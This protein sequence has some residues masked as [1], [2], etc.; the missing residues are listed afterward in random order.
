[1]TAEDQKPSC[2]SCSF[3][4]SLT[5]LFCHHTVACQSLKV[6]LFSVRTHHPLGQN[7]PVNPLRP[8]YRCQDNH[9]DSFELSVRKNSD[10][11]VKPGWS[12][13][14]ISQD[15]TVDIETQ[16]VKFS[17]DYQCDPLTLPHVCT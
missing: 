9:S 11:N 6:F 1:M 14:V 3:E 7:V 5:Q 8:S 4:D 17:T 10:H 16:H 2:K 12:V 15:S 13:H